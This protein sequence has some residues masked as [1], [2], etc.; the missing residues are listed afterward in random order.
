[1]QLVKQDR[2]EDMLTC[3]K[4]EEGH[5]LPQR[6]D[7]GFRTGDPGEHDI[8]WPLEEQVAQSAGQGRHRLSVLDVYVPCGQVV[9]HVPFG[10][11]YLLVSVHTV[12]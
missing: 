9:T 6:P 1:M 8:H 12:H 11:A 10:V 7:E 5:V 2:H 4:V 3:Q